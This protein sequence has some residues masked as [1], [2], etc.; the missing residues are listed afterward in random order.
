[1]IQRLLTEGQMPKE[2]L[3][4]NLGITIE[5]LKQLCSKKIPLALI[6]RINLPLV[7]LY[8]RAQF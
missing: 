7:K 2:K 1:M 6:P 4:K 3:A 8:C 5:N